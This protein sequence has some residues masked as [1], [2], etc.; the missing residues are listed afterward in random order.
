MRLCLQDWGMA[1]NVEQNNQ[2]WQPAQHAGMPHQQPLL[3][4]MGAFHQPTPGSL[5]A[6]VKLCFM[7]VSLSGGQQ[8]HMWTIVLCFL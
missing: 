8:T 5:L 4:S 2:A 3:P 6:Q 7:P 1:S